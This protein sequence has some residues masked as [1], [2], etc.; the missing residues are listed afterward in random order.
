MLSLTSPAGIYKVHVL[1]AA[2]EQWYVSLP[3][4]SPPSLCHRRHHGYRYEV[5]DLH[6]QEVLPQMVAISE[7]Y[8]QVFKRQ[9]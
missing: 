3:L 8:I 2:N 5:Q 6:I 9:L 1:H 7:A 4:F